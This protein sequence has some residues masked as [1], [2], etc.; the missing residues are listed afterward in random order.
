MCIET[1]EIFD[2]AK[3]AAIL[4]PRKSAEGLIRLC[5]EGKQKQTCGYHFIYVK[6]SDDLYF[7]GVFWV[8]ANSYRDILIGN[9]KL[10]THKYLVDINGNEI[11]KSSKSSK[12]HKHVW[13]DN[14]LPY[15]YYPR[16]RVNIYDGEV[17][18]NL[19]SR[20]NL[21]QV[22][23]KIIEEFGIKKLID[24]ITIYDIDNIQ[25]GNHYDFKLK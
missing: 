21:P 10:K 23:N 14:S 24:K 9:F 2:S 16:G 18:I 7:N 4:V 22:I 5:C 3:E 6:A 1:G 20:I 13:G 17:F 8:I 15:D 19:N 12:T 11:E 25:D